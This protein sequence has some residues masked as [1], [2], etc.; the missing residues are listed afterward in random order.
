[1]TE[2]ALPG[3]GC[4]APVAHRHWCGFCGAQLRF[5]PLQ[6]SRLVSVPPCPRCRSLDWRD[7]ADALLLT[8]EG[9]PGTSPGEP[10]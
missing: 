3:A 4:T 10:A 9:I 5:T 1:M 2:P 7:E 8:G 6:C